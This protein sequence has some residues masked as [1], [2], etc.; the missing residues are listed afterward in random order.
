[1][2]QRCLNANNKHYPNYGGRGIQ[3][4]ERWTKFKNFL[5]DMG[6]RP[7]GMT[8]DRRDPEGG[9]HCGHCAECVRLGHTANCRWADR[10][11]QARNKRRVGKLLRERNEALEE[12]ARLSQV[13]RQAPLKVKKPTPT[14]DAAQGMLF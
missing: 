2:K 9:Y 6:E 12:L 4:C 13:P 8:V 7:D 14:L 11:T 3:V 5:A 10:D 1:M